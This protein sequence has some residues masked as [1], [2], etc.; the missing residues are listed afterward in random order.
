MLMNKQ[1]Q[2]L[3][4]KLK[5]QLKSVISGELSALSYKKMMKSNQKLKNLKMKK[6]RQML[7][8]N[9][10]LIHWMMKLNQEK[11][12]M[13]KK[14]FLIKWETHLKCSWSMSQVKAPMQP[15][16]LICPKK[17]MRLQCLFHYQML[18]K[19]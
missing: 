17:L 15:D 8:K 2:T 7:M 4:L 5:L 3:I 9:Q 6:L 14:A 18:W 16:K 19:I 11:K 1:L 12:K 10:K 13:K